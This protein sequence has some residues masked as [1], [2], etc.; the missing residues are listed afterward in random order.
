MPTNRVALATAPGHSIH[1]STRAW[2]AIPVTV[3]V[4]ASTAPVTE[5][6]WTTDS[7]SSSSMWLSR[8]CTSTWYPGA[9]SSRRRRR[10]AWAESGSM[11]CHAHGSS[12]R[13]SW[14]AGGPRA[15]G[16]APLVRM[17]TI[18][19]ASWAHPA[20]RSSPRPRAPPGSREAV[21]AAAGVDEAP[22]G[23]AGVDDDGRSGSSAPP[24][25]KA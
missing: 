24:R 23:A 16:I 1:G 19:V 21:V 7:A 25:C 6:S 9:R 20:Q 2:A 14:G 18:M 15:M 5:Y 17:V 11:P 3:P 22:G 8:K 10:M 12:D 13:S 4:A